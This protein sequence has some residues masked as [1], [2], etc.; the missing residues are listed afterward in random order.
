[1]NAVEDGTGLVPCARHPGRETALR[2]GKCGVPIC[3][4]CVVQTPVGG[5]CPTCANLRRLP[6]FDVGLGLTARAVLG[7]LAAS[8]VGWYLLSFVP[9]LRY[10][11]SILVGVAV[12]EG[13]S[14]LARRRTSVVLEVAAVAVVVVGLLVIEM[15]RMGDGARLF[16]DMADQPGLGLAIV[17]PGVIA[18]LVAVVKLR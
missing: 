16:R 10:F 2:C 4:R 9:Y 3:V 18:S 8:L 6:Q 1:V 5:R 15:L 7:G 12:G 11:L 17:L 14:R 13:M